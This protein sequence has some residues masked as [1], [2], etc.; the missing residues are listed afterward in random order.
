MKILQLF[1]GLGRQTRDPQDSQ[2]YRDRERQKKASRKA[3]EKSECLLDQLEHLFCSSPHPPHHR[4]SSSANEDTYSC[5]FSPLHKYYEV[6]SNFVFE[7]PNKVLTTIQKQTSD[8]PIPP[9]FLIQFTLTLRYARIACKSNK[10]LAVFLLSLS[11]S[12]RQSGRGRAC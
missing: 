8:S 10:A 9:S 4:V 6:V 11:H 7:L 1:C 12:P 5:F 2:R 3:S